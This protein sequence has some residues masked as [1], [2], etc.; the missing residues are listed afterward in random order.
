MPLERFLATACKD[1]MLWYT[2]YL[3]GMDSIKT[4]VFIARPEFIHFPEKDEY[5]LVQFFYWRWD[6]I[7]LFLR[8]RQDLDS[9]SQ[10]RFNFECFVHEVV[11]YMIMTVCSGSH[12]AETICHSPKN[13]EHSIKL[14][15]SLAWSNVFV[16]TQFLWCSG[17]R[18]QP[19]WINSVIGCIHHPQVLHRLMQPESIGMRTMLSRIFSL[20]LEIYTLGCC[21]CSLWTVAIDCVSSISCIFALT[22]SP[23]KQSKRRIPCSLHFPFHRPLFN[24]SSFTTCA[25]LNFHQDST[26]IFR[27]FGFSTLQRDFP[28]CS[29][30]P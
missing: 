10:A 25:M 4:I 21:G 28:F 24:R 7:H 13:P 2:L 18:K 3:F 17:G 16:P 8:V 30:F 29:I 19:N 14:N 1:D 11:C 22:S 23:S 15:F 5:G 20:C 27:S 9:L 26:S 12:P 6:H